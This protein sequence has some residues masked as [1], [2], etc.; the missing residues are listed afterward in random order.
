MTE[1]KRETVAPDFTHLDAKGRARMVDVSAKPATERTAVAA[2]RLVASEEVV[3]RIRTADL[4][5]GDAL[6]VAKIAGIMAAKRTDELIPLC[7]PLPI[8][9]VDLSFRFLPDGRSIE[10]ESC[11]KTTAP[12]GV[13]MEALTAASTALL[14]LYDMAKALDRSMTITDVRLIEKRGGRSGHYVREED[15]GS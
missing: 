13:E 1:D 3:E 15:G 8:T 7:H 5:K 10:V 4:A 12:T 2:G 14:T 6:A 11:V 9:S